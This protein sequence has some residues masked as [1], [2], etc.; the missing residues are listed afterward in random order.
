M[1][2]KNLKGFSKTNLR[3]YRQF[4][5]AYPQIRQSLTDKFIN[6][7]LKFLDYQFKNEVTEKISTVNRPKPE[8]LL[9]HLTFTHFVELIKIQDPVKR[10]FYEIESTTFGIHITH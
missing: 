7:D 10:A 3:L 1:K 9:R 5:L 2:S 4:Y 8:I 6:T